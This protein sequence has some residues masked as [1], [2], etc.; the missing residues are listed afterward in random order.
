[1]PKSRADQTSLLYFIASS[2]QTEKATEIRLPLETPAKRKKTGTGK[3]KALTDA[4]GKEVDFLCGVVCSNE[5][6]RTD[7]NLESARMKQEIADLKLC[8]ATVRHLCVHR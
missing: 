6:E 4:V 8:V 7:M 1:M 5:K 3:T 2:V